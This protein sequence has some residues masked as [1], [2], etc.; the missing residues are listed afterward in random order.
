M[1]T[2][3]DILP[4][5]AAPSVSARPGCAVGPQ[6]LS[7]RQRCERQ[8]CTPLCALLW[9]RDRPAWWSPDMH[10]SDSETKSPV[11]T[12]WRASWRTVHDLF[13]GRT[14]SVFKQT[15]MQETLA[16][17][18]SKLYIRNVKLNK[19]ITIHFMPKK[20]TVM[21]RDKRVTEERAEE[22]EERN[23]AVWVFKRHRRSS[24]DQLKQRHHGAE[25]ANKEKW[26]FKKHNV[27]RQKLVES[28]KK[29][30]KRIKNIKI[31]THPVIILVFMDV[32]RCQRCLR[33]RALKA[34]LYRS[35][36]PQKHIKKTYLFW[37]NAL[38]HGS[39]WNTFRLFQMIQLV[40]EAIQLLSAKLSAML[41][42]LTLPSLQEDTHALKKKWM[43]GG[44]GVNNTVNQHFCYRIFLAFL[45][46]YTLW[47]PKGD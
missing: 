36:P 3:L 32:I 22:I 31:K 18:Y 17:I 25:E 44:R 9:S 45:S 10:L 7:W 38:Q 39:I 28:K 40:R 12:V 2:A 4:W 20:F 1:W 46:F 23:D 34:K 41:R 29:K 21:H 11:L 14:C 47:E 27:W 37:L 15:L 8:P 43:K 13:R 42:L 33:K 19:S 30:K 35:L 6:C 16:A 5:R 26:K 24:W